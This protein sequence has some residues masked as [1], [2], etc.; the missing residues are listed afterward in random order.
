[1]KFWDI[2]KLNTRK[3]EPIGTLGSTSS[4]PTEG[5]V[6]HRGVS[7]V[8][9]D[10]SGSQLLVSCTNSKYGSAPIVKS[11]YSHRSNG[12][13]R[14]VLYNADSPLDVSPAILQGHKVDSFYGK[15][16]EKCTYCSVV[17]DVFS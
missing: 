9:L 1:M 3:L 8:D 16:P 5:V 15:D 2:R 13:F 4:S 11:M 12:L 7:L 14:I 10:C 6:H 17:G